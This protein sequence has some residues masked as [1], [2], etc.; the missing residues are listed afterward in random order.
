MRTLDRVD[1]SASSLARTALLTSSGLAV[2]GSCLGFAAMTQGAMGIA[3][4][5]LIT[6][7]GVFGALLLVILLAFRSVRT[8]RVAVAAVAFYGAYLCAG[9]LIALLTAGQHESALIYLQW[10]FPLLILNRMVNAPRAGQIAANILLV[11]PL[12]I[13]VAFLGVLFRDT[14]PTMVYLTLVACLSY[15][16]FSFMLSAVSRYREAYI[17]ESERGKS[18]SMQAEVLESI[19]DCFISMDGEFRLTYANDTACA[20]LGIERKSLIGSELRSINQSLFPAW[21]LAELS[22]TRGDVASQHEIQSDQGQWYEMRCFSH[23]ERI[24][25][26]FRNVTEMVTSRHNLQA[27]YERLREQS[28]LLDKAQDAIFVQDFD[29]RI[30]YWNKG[31]EDLFGWSAEEILGRRAADL[32][33]VDAEAIVPAW[34]AIVHGGEWSGELEKR[35]KDGTRITVES[36]VKAL[37]EE[38]GHPRSVLTINTD[39]TDRKVA[40]DRIHNLAFYDHLT[41]LANRTLLMERLEEILRRKQQRDHHAALLF[42]DLDDFKTL[43]DTAGHE[44]GDGLLKEIA[45]RLRQIIRRSDSVARFGGDEFVVILEEL[46]SD[47][48]KATA[49]ARRVGEKILRACREPY[50]TAHCSFEST[51]SIGITL[52]VPHCV[53]VED[54]LK[55]ADLAMYQAKEQGRNNLCFFDSSMEVSASERAVLLADM[56]S[57]LQNQEF[58]LHFQ[59]QLDSSF[60]I[61]GCEALLR[62]RHPQRGNVSPGEF[63]PLAESSG[64]IVDMGAWV[65]RTACRQLAYWGG[66]PHMRSLEMSV[67]VSPRQF[68]DKDFERLV[69]N[70]V[71][72][73]GADPR[74]LKLEITESV[75]MENIEETLSTMTALKALG[76]G[77]SL[78][79]FGTGYSSLSQLKRLPLDQLKVDQSFVRG[80]EQAETDASIVRTI[81]GLGRELGLN[82]LAEGVETAQQYGFLKEHDCHSFQGFLFSPALPAS[83]F[84]SFVKDF[85]RRDGGMTGD[86]EPRFVEAGDYPTAMTAAD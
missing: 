49:E 2:L 20:E 52:F 42:I 37:R 9:L 79:D 10:F 77:F 51:A 44:A 43:N 73:S 26:A 3:E 59:P 29:T 70:V 78:D 48:G 46:S 67:N 54:L 4:G 41:G 11:L 36:R 82:V 30:L 12:A 1:L 28:E 13:I 27:A 47:R 31:A 62:W 57:A 24:S 35:K 84:E 63:I 50:V 38:T 16:L 65:L 23:P 61:T 71:A 76:I 72:E 85:S 6:C 14:Q 69:A 74:Q 80:V 40:E 22:S 66:Q 83:Q 33:L 75:M 58:S 56:R 34:Q 81:I 64:L 8:Q 15:T 53:T 5:V 21:M 17:V 19:S 18:L 55:R 60:H 32:L 7:G 86:A 39:I 45:R 68:L 25:I